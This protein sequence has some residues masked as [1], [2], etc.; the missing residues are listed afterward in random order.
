M[1]IFILLE[2]ETRITEHEFKEN[3]LFIVLTTGQYSG[4]DEGME[5]IKRYF[6]IDVSENINEIGEYH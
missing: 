5:I 3:C 2:Q 1:I 4:T 6:D